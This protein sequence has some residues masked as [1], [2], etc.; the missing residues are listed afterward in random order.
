MERPRSTKLTFFASFVIAFSFVFALLLL[1]QGLVNASLVTCDGPPPEAWRRSVAWWGFAGA[2]LFD[3]VGAGLVV[4]GT[5]NAL[6]VALVLAVL[7]FGA[8][9]GAFLLPLFSA[10]LC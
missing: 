10:G 4:R 7:A 3:L 8:S 5:T 2:A 1:R 6:I 9:I